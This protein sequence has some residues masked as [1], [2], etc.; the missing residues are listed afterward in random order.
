MK[1]KNLFLACAILFATQSFAVP[2]NREES[3]FRVGMGLG[4]GDL[5]L[6][7]SVVPLSSWRLN[8]SLLAT[9]DYR[10]SSWLQL[11]GYIGVAT[12]SRSHPEATP[13][14]VGAD[15]ELFF[16][17]YGERPLFEIAIAG[18]ASNM[19][20]TKS[21]NRRL[22]PHCGIRGTTYWGDTVFGFGMMR[23]NISF[24]MSEVGIGFRL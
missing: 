4:L 10:V 9:T 16:L 1:M 24:I 19:M 12:S 7:S 8:G 17:S 21:G 11:H 15:V 23:T 22:S 2:I 18:G 13:V 6:D 14:L 5:P 20:N 3:P